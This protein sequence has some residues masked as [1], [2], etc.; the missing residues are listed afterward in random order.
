MCS[1]IHLRNNE[2]GQ[3]REI[4]NKTNHQKGIRIV[5]H[6]DNI[7]NGMGVIS[8]QLNVS[9][10]ISNTEALALDFTT[11]IRFYL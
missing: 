6:Q 8:S 2:K 11:D 9:E 5:G 7:I 3:Q 10:Q 4:V 1:E